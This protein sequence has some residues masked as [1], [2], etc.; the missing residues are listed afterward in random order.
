MGTSTGYL[1]PTGH[2]WTDSKRDVSAMIRND[3]SSNSIGKAISS[4]AKAINITGLSRQ[5]DS[6]IGTTGSKILSFA[7]LVGSYGLN[8]AL[9]RVGLSE[10][11]GKNPQEIFEGLINYF[12][13]GT[14][15]LQETIA[16][17]A[18]Q[19]YIEDL[20]E[21]IGSNEELENILSELKSDVFIRDYLIKYVQSFFFTYFSEK[22]MAKIEDM[23]RILQ[24]Q[25][26]IKEYIGI[27]VTEGYKSE[28][29]INVDWKGR[30]GKEYIEN[31]CREV[32]DVF[33]RWIENYED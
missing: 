16:N 25:E 15:S 22:I 33:E 26:R 2:L 24:I 9:S 27:V 18:M 20:A 13:E 4:F 21:S 28:G 10:L 6:V 19:E 17:Q 11:I 14:N 23:N 8:G 7:G 30:Q 1:P 12:S 31:K 29:L 3:F 5:S 32:W